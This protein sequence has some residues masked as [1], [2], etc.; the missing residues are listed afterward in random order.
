MDFTFGIITGGG[1]DVMINTIID[2]I[3]REKIPN[4]EV[5]VI[6]LSNIK[7]EHVNIIPFDET[8]K[9]RW[10]TKKKNL[11]TSNAMYDNIV[12]MHDYI[13]FNSGWYDGQLTA[14][15]DYKVRVDKILTKEGKRFRD[16]CIWPNNGNFMDKLIGRQC[17][18]PYDIKNL[19]KYMYVSGSYWVAKK[20]VMKDFPL[21][22]GLCWGQGEDVEWS[23]RIRLR[24][25]F[26]MNPHS[27]VQILKPNKNIAF[28]VS[29][30]ITIKKLKEI[31]G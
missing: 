15:D 26:S 22:E 16:W 4:Y 19:S 3:Q 13:S 27:T 30:E 18:I 7:R 1:N 6:G 20:S 29:D 28:E 21:N 25:D 11:I 23:K 14:G 31:N 24:Y 2:S 10:I 9:Q 5:I 12:F 17:L 8:Q